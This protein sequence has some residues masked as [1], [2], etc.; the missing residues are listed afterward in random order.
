MD[1]HALTRLFAGFRRWLAVLNGFEASGGQ[2][3]HLAIVTALA[4]Q[5]P[6]RGDGVGFG[7]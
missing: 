3:N 5:T 4:G 2:A 6:R 1:F 7:R